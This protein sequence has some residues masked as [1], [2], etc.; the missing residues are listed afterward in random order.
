MNSKIKYINKENNETVNRANKGKLFLVATPIGNLGDITLR[1]LETLKESDEILAE[2]TRVSSKLLNHYSIKKPI[3]SFNAHNA[4][5]KVKEVS[6]KLLNGKNISLITDAGTPAISDPGAELV[7]YIFENN[8]DIKVAPIPGVS[9]LTAALSVAG[10]LKS[11]FVFLGFLPHKK[12]RETLFNEMVKNP[13]A[14]VFFESP[15]RLTKT[16][17]SLSKKLNLDQKVVVAR[18]LTKLHEDIRC[19]TATKLLE[20]YKSNSC[21][22]RG[23]LVIIV[24]PIK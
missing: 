7:K 3:S 10:L 16:L 8:L 18:E 13:R 23:E 20:H 2:D 17:E 11:D 9:S 4:S 24:F 5:K 1:A 15:H 21:T 14:V 19:A 22:I 6:E 12:G